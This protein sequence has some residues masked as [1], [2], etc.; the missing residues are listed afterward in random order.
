MKNY[1]CLNFFISR[2]GHI[3]RLNEVRRIS[4][5]LKTYSIKHQMQKTKLKTKS[6]IIL[7]TKFKIIEK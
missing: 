1:I 2:S 7:K 6:K 4:N 3:L 5:L